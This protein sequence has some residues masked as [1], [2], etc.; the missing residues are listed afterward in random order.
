M[1]RAAGGSYAPGWRVAFAW[2][3]GGSQS[4]P[5]LSV[6][7]REAQPREARSPRHLSSFL[8]FFSFKLCFSPDPVNLG[9]EEKMT[10]VMSL[11]KVDTCYQS[12]HPLKSL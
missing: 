12:K 10:E 5:A 11:L 3:V 2:G 8:I 4:R 1:N 9:Q 7:T 6:E